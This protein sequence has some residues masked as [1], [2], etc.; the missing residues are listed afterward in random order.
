[1]G[2]NNQERINKPDTSLV[3]FATV[4]KFLLEREEDIA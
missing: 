4:V 3:A 1:M 2:D